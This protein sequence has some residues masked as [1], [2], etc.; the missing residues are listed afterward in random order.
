L[1][2]LPKAAYGTQR[3]VLHASNIGKAD[4][5]LAVLGGLGRTVVGRRAQRL[6]QL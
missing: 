1:A 3:A 5:K 6:R 2:V 4:Q